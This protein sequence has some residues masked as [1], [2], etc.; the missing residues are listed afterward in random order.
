MSLRGFPSLSLFLALT[1][2]LVYFA[3]RHLGA[4]DLWC[5]AMTALPAAVATTVLFARAHRAAASESVFLGLLGLS[6]LLWCGGQVLWIRVLAQ[7]D[8]P[9]R[10]GA[11]PLMDLLFVGFVV[12]ALAAVLLGPRPRLFR[13]D[14]LQRLDAL[15]LAGSVSFVFLRLVFLPIAD[16]SGGMGL[17]AV[18][19]AALCLAL[20]A[21]GGVR[22]L[23]ADEPGTRRGYGLVSTFAFTYGVGSAVANGNGPMAP[24]GSLLDLAWFVPFFLLASVAMAPRRQ[25]AAVPSWGLVLLVGSLPL[26]LD[27]FGHLLWGGEHGGPEVEILLAF[28]AFVGFSCMVR[29]WLQDARDAESRARDHERLE[30]ERRSGRL[31]ALSAV[32]GPLLADLRRTVDLV[33]TRATLAEG[34]LG[35]EAAHVREQVD[36]A[37]ALTPEIEAAFGSTTHRAHHELDLVRTLERALR[38]EVDA[39]LDARVRLLARGALPPVVGEPRSLAAAFRELARNA[40]RASPGG[41][42]EVR[43]DREEGELVI[44]F[45]D[46]GPGIPEEIRPHVFDPFFTTSPAGGGVGLGLTLVHFVVRDLGGYVRVEAAGGAGT[47]VVLR[48]PVQDRRA[49]AGETHPLVWPILATSILLTIASV[50]PEAVAAG[51]LVAGASV[52]AGLAAGFELLRAARALGSRVFF[53][54]LAVGALIAGLAPLLGAPGLRTLADW[55]F[56]AAVLLPLGGGLPTRGRRYVGVLALLAFAFAHVVLVLRPTLLPGAQVAMIVAF[57]GGCLRLLL[58]GAAA[59]LAARADE[60]PDRRA[61][62][63]LSLAL[64][65]WAAGASAEPWLHNLAPTGSVRF[66]ELGVVLPLLVLLGLGRDEA[67]RGRR[68]LLPAQGEVAPRDLSARAAT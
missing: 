8:A 15:L 60:V 9:V 27:V 32:S 26:V 10:E 5:E 45:K 37:R 61:L 63:T 57:S 16:A 13:P 68:A 51:R 4:P 18:L 62:E 38:A 49:R 12:P 7:G 34:A 54:L 35:R 24:P 50:L 23:F 48:I 65:F 36:R 19:L 47:T 2:L 3:S 43:V 11:H 22:F 33:E 41:S 42:L 14:P 46:D 25:W 30:E 40:A 64:A 44:R 21:I 55:P 31:E 52:A 6:S 39:G 58:A 28:A 59:L 56:A 66:A 53:A 67:G 20:A 29:L 1:F 17:R